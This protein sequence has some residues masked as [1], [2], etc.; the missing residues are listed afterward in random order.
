MID[1]L[2]RKAWPFIRRLSR[3][4]NQPATAL[5]IDRI[6]IILNAWST[7]AVV[8]AVALLLHPVCLHRPPLLRR[9][10]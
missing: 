3:Y 1:D 8:P 4:V 5:A 9:L 2:H 10:L 7:A 6:M